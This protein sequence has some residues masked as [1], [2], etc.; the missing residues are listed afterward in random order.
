M[1]PD[2]YAALT[3]A[4]AAYFGQRDASMPFRDAL[5]VIDQILGTAAT[6]PARNGLGRGKAPF[7]RMY[8]LCLGLNRVALGIGGSFHFLH[9][10]LGGLQLTFVLFAGHHAVEQAIF[11]LGYFAFGV[12]DFM[13]E[14]R[15]GRWTSD[16]WKERP[17]NTATRAHVR[18]HS[19]N[20]AY[21]ALLHEIQNA[22][23]EIAKAEDRLLDRMVAGEEYERQLKA[24]E[25]AGVKVVE[26]ASN[27]ERHAIQAR[28]TSGAKGA[29]RGRGRTR[30]SRRG[31]GPRIWSITTSASRNGMEASRWPKSREGCGQCGVHIRPHMI[32]QLAARWKWRILSTVRTCT[33]DSFIPITH[34][35]SHRAPAASPTAEPPDG[36]NL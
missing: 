34:P 17:R 30:R 23:G 18:F 25:A 2:V 9:G 28:D 19:T 35:R 29:C 3:A 20:E 21:K 26:T 13:Q 8:W 31:C 1:W 36:S 10:R 15:L 4:F 27:A 5:V 33:A 12:L 22:E 32:Q 11:S 6:A 7:A 24:A 14:R 16:N